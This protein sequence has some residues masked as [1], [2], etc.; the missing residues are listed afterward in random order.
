MSELGKQILKEISYD[1]FAKIISKIPSNIFFKDTDL[2]YRFTSHYWQEL[3][4]KDIVGKTDLDIRK[5][6]ENALKAM[7]ADREIIR[8][9]K[10]CQY[11]IKSDIDDNERYLELIKEPISDDNGEILGIVGLINDI[12]EK[13]LMEQQLREV[14]ASQKMFTASMNH[15]LRSPLNGVIGLLQILKEDNTLTKT[16]HNYVYNAYQSAEL[17]LQIVNDLLDYA[18]IGT[19]EFTIK[20]EV[21][22]LRDVISNIEQNMVVMADAKGLK[23]KVNVDD[24]CYCLLRGDEI[25][26]K[27]ILYNIIS[28]GIKYTDKGEVE[29]SVTYN[30]GN[31]ILACADTGQ[32]ISEESI[33]VL[34]DPFVRVNEDMN[35]HIQG[36]GLGLSIVKRIIEKM[37]GDIQ[38]ES[39]LNVGTNFVITIPVAVEDKSVRYSDERVIVPKS[40]QN[41]DLS[42]Y[43]VLCVDDTRVNVIVFEGLLKSTGIKVDKA[44]SGQQAIDKAGRNKYDIIFMDHQMPNMSGIEAFKKI[45]EG[46][47]D[48]KN[49]PIVVLTANVGHDLE[50]EYARIGFNGYL[51]KPIIKEELIKLIKK[52]LN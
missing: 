24:D 10:G 43:A 51:N 9:G 35:R 2:R 8:T 36:T 28:N 31:L 41:E 15:E 19:N 16:Q 7:E 47:S 38:V 33:K 14:N 5:D 12:T 30:D 1:T 46:S 50:D 3:N 4:S 52:I 26:I 20:K 44:L 13:K 25:R 23:F 18:K 32:G 17:M 34:F 21:F 6:K 39:E 29:L 40:E 22:D 11:E 42:Q 27:Q 45:R 48:N 49:T 37:D